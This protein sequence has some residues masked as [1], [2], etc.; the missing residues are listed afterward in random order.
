[1]MNKYLETKALTWAYI[2][3]RVASMSRHFF[4]MYGT[5]TTS[6]F[7]N[8]FILFTSFF[9]DQSRFSNEFEKEVFHSMGMDF[10]FQLGQQLDVV[11]NVIREILS[12]KSM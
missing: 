4:D 3:L 9:I 2:S 7:V 1:M 5:I 8:I 12:V 11:I 6:S 10:V